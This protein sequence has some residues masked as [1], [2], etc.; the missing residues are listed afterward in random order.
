MV[1]RMA[2]RYL[3]TGIQVSRFRRIK[4]SAIIRPNVPLRMK[5]NYKAEK[6]ELGF[7]ISNPGGDVVYS[8]GTVSLG[9]GT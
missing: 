9:A 1:M 6:G 7:E 3:G 2:S 4:F 8:S 5:L